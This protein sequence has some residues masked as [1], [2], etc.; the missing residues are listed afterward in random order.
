MVFKNWLESF[1]PFSEFMQSLLYSKGFSHVVLTV[2]RVLV[3]GYLQGVV[4]EVYS[5]IKVLRDVFIALK[6]S[7]LQEYVTSTQ[8]IFQILQQM[9]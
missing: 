1:G 4:T 6:A 3:R 7:I 2:S 9:I 5:S 8:S